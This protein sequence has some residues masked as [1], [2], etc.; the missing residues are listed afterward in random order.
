MPTDKHHFAIDV[1]RREIAK[2]NRLEGEALECRDMD[3]VHQLNIKMH[4]L[5]MSE[6]KLVMDQESA[7]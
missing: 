2:L 5:E 1:I 6:M 4:Q 7:S 3:A